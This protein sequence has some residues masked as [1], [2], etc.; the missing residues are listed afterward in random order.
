MHPQTRA[1]EGEA[2]E[3]E[4]VVLVLGVLGERA[5]G[6]GENAVGD[7]L[8]HLLPQGADDDGEACG[9]APRVSTRCSF[10]RE[11]HADNEKA[12]AR[13]EV[14][15]QAQPGVRGPERAGAPGLVGSEEHLG[16]RPPKQGN[17]PRH[18]WP[19]GALEA[20][21]QWPP[22]RGAERG[23]S[24]EPQLRRGTQAEDDEAGGLHHHELGADKYG[25][26]DAVAP[27]KGPPPVCRLLPQLHTQPPKVLHRRPFQGKRHQLLHGGE[28]DHGRELVPQ[29]GEDAIHS[30]LGGHIPR[31]RDLD[32][33]RFATLV[34]G[35]GHGVGCIVCRGHR[36]RRLEEEAR[37]E[38]REDTHAL[39]GLGHDLVRGAK[40]PRAPGAC[41]GELHGELHGEALAVS[42]HAHAHACEG[43]CCGVLWQS[44]EARGERRGAG[45]E[46]LEGAVC[47]GFAEAHGVELPRGHSH[48]VE[49]G[50]EEE[51]AR[52]DGLPIRCDARVRTKIKGFQRRAPVAEGTRRCEGRLVRD[53]ARL[54]GEHVQAVPGV[55]H[56][57]RPLE[58]WRGEGIDLLGIRERG[59]QDGLS[60]H[61]SDAL[62][63][64]EEE[65]AQRVVPVPVPSH[66]LGDGVGRAV[67]EV[68]V[69]EVADAQAAHGAREGDATNVCQTHS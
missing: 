65:L 29:G 62:V 60:S 45:L 6:L 58:A 56:G 35:V 10:R 3:V 44:G 31:R 59:I 55:A 8:V 21:L 39:G 23:D 17:G 12:H 2:R 28:R 53:R 13:H 48:D 20:K 40:E 69:G 37:C 16:V 14:E 15:E 30:E 41:R 27:V 22:E 49:R 26:D 51:E 61:V 57:R 54:E 11:A 32:R 34:H 19:Q 66:R 64:A 68:I 38:L 18:V 1:S 4:P 42:R 52:Q 36:A 46:D 5:Q 33:R 24:L 43:V 50:R 47:E 63:A 67:A 25:R 9:S 7:E